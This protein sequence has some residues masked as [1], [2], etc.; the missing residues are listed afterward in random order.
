MQ[1][2]LTGDE[3]NDVEDEDRLFEGSPVTSAEYMLAILVFIIRFKLRSQCLNELLKLNCFHV[4][5][6][7][8]CNN[9]LQVQKIF[10]NDWSSNSSISLLLIR[11]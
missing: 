8:M 5:C 7:E 6:Q 1:D 10:C 9:P 2:F 3:M 11:M 4:S